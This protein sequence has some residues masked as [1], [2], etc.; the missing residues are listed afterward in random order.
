MSTKNENVVDDWECI[1]DSEVSALTMIKIHTFIKL[2][3]N[4][5][6]MCEKKMSKTMQLNQIFH[7]YY[8]F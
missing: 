6:K 1:D 2:T 5:P 7:M 8:I 4:N 3:H